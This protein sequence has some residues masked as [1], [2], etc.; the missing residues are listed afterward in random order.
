MKWTENYSTLFLLHL[1]VKKSA[2][3]TR[4]NRTTL[5]KRGLNSNAGE[6]SAKIF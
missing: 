5:V 1:S 4:N 6:K 3:D 2:L